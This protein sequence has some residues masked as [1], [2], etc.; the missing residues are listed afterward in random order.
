VI[1]RTLILSGLIC[2][3]TGFLLVAGI[4]H[5]VSSTT[6]GGRGFTA[7]LVSW[8]AKFNPIAMIFTA[9]L[10][11]FLSTGM[12]EVMTANLVTNSFFSQV[13]IGITFLMIIGCEFFINYRIIF[14]HKK[15]SSSE[16]PVPAEK[17]DDANKPLPNPDD[18]APQSSAKEED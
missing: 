10:V 2:G 8:L 14:R 13:V 4:N 16:S 9:L 7:I 17:T 18:S 1:I 15:I 3:V 11:A 5:T 12:D 6:A